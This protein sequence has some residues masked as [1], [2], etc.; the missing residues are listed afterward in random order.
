MCTGKHFCKLNRRV[1]WLLPAVLLAGLLCGCQMNSNGVVDHRQ[2][3]SCLTGRPLRQGD[4]FTSHIVLK[5]D[6]KMLFPNADC[7]ESELNLGYNVKSVDR[8]GQTVVEVTVTSLK[9]F[10]RTMSL[11][12]V[13]DSED[14]AG[15]QKSAQAKENQQKKYVGVFAALKG[16]KY[17]ALVDVKNRAVELTE[18]NQA[19]KNIACGAPDG[20]MFGGD[21]ARMLFNEGALK[22][23][24][25]PTL[26]AGSDANSAPAGA[27]VVPGAAVDKIQRIYTAAEGNSPEAVPYKIT[28]VSNEEQVATEA[29]KAAKSSGKQFQIDSIQGDGSYAVA[30][31][32]SPV[33]KMQEKMF[34]KMKSSGKAG[35]GY[36]IEKTVEIKRGRN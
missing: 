25:W 18:M 32:G 31:D 7:K 35:M 12:F 24:V 14:E 13:Y 20:D 27:A 21:Q 6:L 19:L 34:V 16:S 29:K 9:A 2:G 17:I 11:K 28:R 5:S 33:L 15:A 8:Q 3:L 22:E 36:A 23:Y 30:A 10:E 4:R 26:F 1:L